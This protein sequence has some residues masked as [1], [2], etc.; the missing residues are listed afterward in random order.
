MFR[1]P[2]VLLE[3]RSEVKEFK[4]FSF[5]DEV[6]DEEFINGSEFFLTKDLTD[7]VGF[8]F[9]P[10]FHVPFPPLFFHSL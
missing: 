6:L 1:L 5:S 7:V 10:N 9:A 2:T 4:D 3:S 8:T